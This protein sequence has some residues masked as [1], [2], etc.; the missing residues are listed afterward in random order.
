MTRQMRTHC[1][2]TGTRLKLRFP[3]LNNINYK[4]Y[5]SELI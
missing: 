2:I 5:E 1:G 3:M 4:L